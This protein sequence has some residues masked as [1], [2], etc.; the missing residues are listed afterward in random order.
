MMLE[1]EFEERIWLVLV[2]IC[3]YH[4]SMVSHVL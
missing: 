3:D 4:I 1:S 2:L